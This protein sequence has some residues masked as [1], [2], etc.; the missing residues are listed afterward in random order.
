MPLY[1]IHP[2]FY[3]PLSLL[4]NIAKMI[5]RTGTA[6]RFIALPGTPIPVRALLG[7]RH[8]PA[9]L[10]VG[11]LRA[12]V[13][14]PYAQQLAL[15][16]RLGRLAAHLA[17][18]RSRVAATNIELCLPDW[19][20]AQKRELLWRHIEAI[21]IGA[22]ETAVTWWASDDYLR[23]YS[24][25]IGAEHFHAAKARGKGV[26]L[27]TGH[28]T[29]M[30]LASHMM[31]MHFTFSAMY[32]P[33]SV[34]VFDA[35][36]KRA[37]TGRRNNRVFARDDPRAMIRAL[38]HNE[39]VWYAIDQ[40]YGRPDALFVPFFGVPAATISATS[41]LARITGAAVVPFLPRRLPGTQG[42]EIRVL[43][44][45]ADF[46]SGDD[47]TDLH[48]IHGLLE[49]HI[50]LVPEQYFWVHRRFKTRPA[51]ATGV[52]DQVPAWLTRGGHKTKTG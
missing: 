14:L 10:G 29:C 44:A 36:M 15:G 7:P 39:G 12:A 21:G 20:A 52:Y 24:R 6:P 17:P 1:A 46:P 38:R 26:I 31:G 2:Y 34:A 9:W 43:P 37:R 8:W 18:A 42:Y 35:Y 47:Y 48:R 16:R 41:R 30:E 45:L 28:F 5:H 49:D 25:V 19:S 13:T 51:G 40:N 3:T 50:R 27:L 22:I 11:L 32:R 33:Q 23:Q 4:S